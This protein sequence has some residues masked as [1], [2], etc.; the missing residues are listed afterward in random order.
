MNKNN[1]NKR[2]TNNKLPVNK[3]SNLTSASN[4]NSNIGKLPLIKSKTS[5]K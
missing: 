1:K 3:S 2:N 5:K 4:I